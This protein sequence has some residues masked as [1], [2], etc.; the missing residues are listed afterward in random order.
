MAITICTVFTKIY[1]MGEGIMSWEKTL[2]AP[3]PILGDSKMYPLPSG[4]NY[5]VGRWLDAEDGERLA[6]EFL[7]RNKK[8]KSKYKYQM[9]TGRGPQGRYWLVYRK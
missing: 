2:K 3:D 9:S 6:T 7:E 4:A 8:R 5:V 1:N